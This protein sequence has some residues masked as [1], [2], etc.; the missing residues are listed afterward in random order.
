MPLLTIRLTPYAQRDL[1]RIKHFLDARDPSFTEPIIKKTLKA[2]RRL[3][4]YPHSA[5]LVD[6]EQGIRELFIAHGSSGYAARYIG[7][8]AWVIVLAIRHQREAA[9]TGSGPASS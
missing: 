5:V 7:E 3:L 8:D 9:S 2:L 1:V 4:V 6:K